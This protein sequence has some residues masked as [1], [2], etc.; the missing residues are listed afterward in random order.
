MTFYDFVGPFQDQILKSCDSPLGERSSL[1]KNQNIPTLR[2]MSAILKIGNHD[3]T[4][5]KSLTHPNII[6]STRFPIVPAINN[7]AK[8]RV[9]Y[10]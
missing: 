1:I 2:Q 9:I 10:F 4:K 3:P 8:Y 6:L 7:A 5:I